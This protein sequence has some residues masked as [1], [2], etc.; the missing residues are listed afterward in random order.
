MNKPTL[1]FI[2]LGIMGKPMVQNLVNNGYQVHVYS[3]LAE[4]VEQAVAGGAIAQPDGLSVAIKADVIITMLPN[5]PQVDEVVFGE[6]GVIT[7]LREGKVWIDM[8]T[9]SSLATKGFAERVQQTGARML[10]APVSGGDKGAKGGSLSIMVGG[11]DAIFNQCLPIFNVLGSRVTHVGG[12][13]AG[14]VTK[15]CNQVLAASTMAALG[16]ALVMGTKAGVDPARII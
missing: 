2:G 11:E 12:N 15:S 3:I 16:E 6:G 7:A 4:D 5:T 10:D 13:G 9:I 14:Q 8:S 1:G